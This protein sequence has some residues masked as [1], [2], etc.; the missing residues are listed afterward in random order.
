ME[1]FYKDKD[2]EFVPF[3]EIPDGIWRVRQDPEL[4]VTSVLKVADLPQAL[5]VSMIKP[6][7]NELGKAIYDATKESVATSGDIDIKSIINCIYNVM[8]S[9][10][11]EWSNM[12]CPLCSMKQPKKRLEWK[13]LVVNLDEYVQ[14]Q[15]Q[16]LIEETEDT[17]ILLEVG[18]DSEIEDEEP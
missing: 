10:N 14:A 11:V 5:R 9:S 8:E 18:E 12:D 7:E 3:R 2:G 6:Y 4:H 1:T 16:D 13:E 17:E 15:R